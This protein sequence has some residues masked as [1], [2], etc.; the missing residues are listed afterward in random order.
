V[1]FDD[2]KVTVTPTSVVQSSEYYPFG[3]QTANSW[4]RPSAVQNNFLFDAGN[5]LNTT[6]AMYDL[7][8]RN[9]DAALGRMFQVNPMSLSSH[10]LN[11]YHYA[12]NNPIGSNDPSGLK[13]MY[14]DPSWGT[15]F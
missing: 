11:P 12:R 8:Y 5:E 9:Y 15:I 13:T 6:T 3:L 7:P 4:T 14:W 10:N 1:Y 2:F